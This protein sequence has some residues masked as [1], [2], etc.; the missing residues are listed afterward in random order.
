MSTHNTLSK[1]ST[2]ASKLVSG[3]SP[4]KRNTSLA[5]IAGVAASIFG[6]GGLTM[7]AA[8]P[9]PT[10]ESEGDRTSKVV[11][12]ERDAPRG[13]SRASSRANQTPALLNGTSVTPST[14]ASVTT[15]SSVRLPLSMSTADL[16]RA[17]RPLAPFP[18]ELEEKTQQLTLNTEAKGKEAANGKHEASPSTGRD[19][20]KSPLSAAPK[21]PWDPDLVRELKES[22]RLSREVG[23]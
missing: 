11:S 23:R 16:P 14:S 22:R 8:R 4:P 9:S 5:N 21:S 10:K 1:A 18:K 6:L 7:T 19:E 15:A 13:R 12:D 2:L 20:S 17:K 3:T